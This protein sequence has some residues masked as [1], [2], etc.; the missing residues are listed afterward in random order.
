[1]LNAVCFLPQ[2][3]NLG[4]ETIHTDTHTHTHTHK[5]ILQVVTHL[6]LYN[7]QEYRAHCLFR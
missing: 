4:Q 3:K 6:H 1:M 7:L 5:T 2:F